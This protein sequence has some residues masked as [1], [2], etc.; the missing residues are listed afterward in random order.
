MTK[1]PNLKSIVENMM[2]PR[3]EGTSQKEGDVPPQVSSFDPA[4][5]NHSSFYPIPVSRW[6]ALLLR[7]FFAVAVVWGLWPVLAYEK[8]EM[9]NGLANFIDVSSFGGE[10]AVVWFRPLIVVAAVLY[11]FEVVRPLGL[12]LLTLAHLGYNTLQ[13]SQ[14]FTFHGN[15]MIGLILLAQCGV[16]LFYLGYKLVKGRSFEFPAGLT[17]YSWQLYVAQSAI[18]AVYVTSAITK[19]GKTHGLWVFRSHYL[20][21]SV[22]KTHRQ[23]FYDNPAGATAEPVVAIAE[24]LAE[25]HVITRMAFAMGF[26]LELFAFLA[27]LN[28]T[29]ALFIG[30]SLIAF[31]FGVEFIMQL[32][33]RVN[34]IMCLIFLANVPFWLVW[35][36]RA[37]GRNES[38]GS[39]QT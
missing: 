33:F 36:K 30:L 2:T 22:V 38:F 3:P 21:K 1:R 13:N 17:R 15:N 39:W 9:A 7:L 18:V 31:H 11:V 24:W 28:R 25:H 34:Q 35:L 29:W 6:E 27:L 10:D 37:I 5:R 20:A 32:D 14:G 4:S 8:I 23:V 16:E 12:M 26:F 19:L